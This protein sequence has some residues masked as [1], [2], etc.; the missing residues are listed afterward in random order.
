MFRKHIARADAAD[1]SNFNKLELTVVKWLHSY[2]A[3]S[4]FNIHTF[5]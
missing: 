3:Q 2:I 1:C 5:S 4:S